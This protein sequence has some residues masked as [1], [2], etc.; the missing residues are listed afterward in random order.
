[1]HTALVWPNSGLHIPPPHWGS[2]HEVLEMPDK[3]SQN[4]VLCVLHYK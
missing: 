3:S 4:T 2:L 1:M